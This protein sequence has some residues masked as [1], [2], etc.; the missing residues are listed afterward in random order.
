[1]CMTNLD[2][3]GRPVFDSG[4]KLELGCSRQKVIYGLPWCATVLHIETCTPRTGTFVGIGQ[5]MYKHVQASWFVLASI[6]F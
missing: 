4:R 3:G 2:G 6:Y 5:A 1:M